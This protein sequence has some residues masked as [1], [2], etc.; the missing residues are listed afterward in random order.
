MKIFLI[1][2]SIVIPIVMVVLQR[3]WWKHHIFFNLA[4]LISALIFGNIASIAIFNIIKDNKVFMTNIHSV[5]L[6]PFFLI[7]GAYLG[8][9]LLYT[10]I[11][12]SLNEFQN[13]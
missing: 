12:R 2:G 1:V 6:N 13:K 11:L 4:A 3:K 8:L 7:T 10:I 5:F 9:Y